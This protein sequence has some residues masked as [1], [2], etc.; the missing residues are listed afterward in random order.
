MLLGPLSILSIQRSLAGGDICIPRV[1]E[2][3]SLQDLPEGIQHEENG[4]ADVRSQEFCF[5]LA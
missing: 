1:D 3:R 5:G 4:N 2:G